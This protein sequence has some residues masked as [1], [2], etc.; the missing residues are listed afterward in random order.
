MNKAFKG[1]SIPFF[2]GLILPEGRGG[3]FYLDLS[4]SLFA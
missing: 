3:K 1:D 2:L 4:Q